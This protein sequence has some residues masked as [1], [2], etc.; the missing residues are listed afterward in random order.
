M[1]PIV[2][3]IGQCNRV[4]FFQVEALIEKGREA[5]EAKI[6]QIKRDLEA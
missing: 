5:A 1:C 2:P 3:D 4:D 6:E